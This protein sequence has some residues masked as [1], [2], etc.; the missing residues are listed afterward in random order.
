MFL[1]VPSA[2]EYD[3]GKQRDPNPKDSSLIGTCTSTCKGF[4]S[5]LA[6]SFFL[7]GGLCQA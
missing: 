2:S 7:L 3:R 1:L 5:T 6:A 4:H